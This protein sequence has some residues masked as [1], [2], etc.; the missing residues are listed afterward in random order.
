MGPRDLKKSVHLQKYL[1]AKRGVND[2]LKSTECL[3]LPTTI[4]LNP[5]L[6]VRENPQFYYYGDPLNLIEPRMAFGCLYKTS[7]LISNKTIGKVSL[8]LTPWKL[9]LERGLLNFYLNSKAN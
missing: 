6:L 4:D 3:L 7:Q 2:G 1:P 5:F 8:Q 9:F